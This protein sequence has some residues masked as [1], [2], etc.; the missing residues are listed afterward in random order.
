[1]TF[2]SLSPERTTC[3][4]IGVLFL[5]FTTWELCK[6]IFPKTIPVTPPIPTELPLPEPPT[7][8]ATVQPPTPLTLEQYDRTERNL[9]ALNREEWCKQFIDEEIERSFRE[10]YL[11]AEFMKL[12][13][14][15][16]RKEDAINRLLEL[17]E[18][19]GLLERHFST[20][21]DF[22]NWEPDEEWY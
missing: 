22:E 11:E 14:E 5:F 20:M 18:R 2:S 7:V 13:R 9:E 12:R 4:L 8:Q 3:L 16:V 21:R 19:R 1:M 17:R 15:E 6:R 10:K